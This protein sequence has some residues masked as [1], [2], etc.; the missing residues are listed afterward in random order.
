VINVEAS[1]AYPRLPRFLAEVARVL[2]PGGH[3]LYADVRGRSEFPGWE[4]A[5]AGTPMR[6]VSPRVINASVLRSLDKKFA[7]V[8]GADRWQ[9]TGVHLASTADSPACQA[10][11]CTASYKTA[12]PST[13]CNAGSS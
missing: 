3:F 8:T 2:R 9:A 6:Q 12:K 7:A 4:A 1:H 10:Q 13:G 5:L 11:G